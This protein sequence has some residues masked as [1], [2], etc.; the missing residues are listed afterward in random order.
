MMHRQSALTRAGGGFDG[1]EGGAFPLMQR[2]LRLDPQ[3]SHSHP[4]FGFGPDAFAPKPTRVH[5][6]RRS[7]QNAPPA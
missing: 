6:T 4:F 2:R 7:Q 1:G 3:C 5:L